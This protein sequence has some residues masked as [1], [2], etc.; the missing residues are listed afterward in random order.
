MRPPK[1]HAKER[2]VTLT[3]RIVNHTTALVALVA[4]VLMLALSAM[5]GAGPVGN[6]ISKPSASDLGL[7]MGAKTVS[8]TPSR[9]R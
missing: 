3:S 1:R 8:G 2:D 6:G 4:V 5:A 9:R 7:S